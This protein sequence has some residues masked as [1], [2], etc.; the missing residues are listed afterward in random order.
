MTDT[1]FGK[2]TRMI[3]LGGSGL[4]DG[5]RLLGF[6]VH[7]DPSAAEVARLVESLLPDHERAWL[8]IESDLAAQ[9]PE[10]LT[11][12]RED[13]SGIV[14]SEVPPLNRPDDFHS[15]VEQQV[16]ALLGAKALL[17]DKD[18]ADAPP[19]TPLDTPGRDNA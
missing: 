4:I 17:D 15:Q 13:T 14:I 9:C 5:F 8:V 16:I 18:P 1:G 7:A 2:P 3:A 10:A 12:L 19:D 6:E 11:R